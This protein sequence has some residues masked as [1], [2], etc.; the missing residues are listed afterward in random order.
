MN[1]LGI[2]LGIVAVSDADNMGRAVFGQRNGFMQARYAT[3]A[4]DELL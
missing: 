3:R 4:L 2:S 1:R